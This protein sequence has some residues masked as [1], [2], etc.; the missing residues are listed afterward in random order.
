MSYIYLP[1]ILAA[2][3]KFCRALGHSPPLFTPEDHHTTCSQGSS[4]VNMGNTQ[5]HGSCGDRPHTENR[6]WGSLDVAQ[7][8]PSVTSPTISLF[9]LRCDL[10]HKQE[11]IAI[12]RITRMLYAYDDYSCN[13]ISEFEG[14]LKIFDYL[15]IRMVEFSRIP[16]YSNIIENLKMESCL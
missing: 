9:A 6:R 10:N 15:N 12:R 1:F 14:Y 8:Q 4:R 3:T 13:R 11:N 2:P 16:H 5:Q 7:F